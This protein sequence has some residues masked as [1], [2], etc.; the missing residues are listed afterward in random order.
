MFWRVLTRHSDALP[1]GGGY[2]DEDY[3]DIGR[4]RRYDEDYGRRRDDG[5]DRINDQEDDYYRDHRPSAP[6][7]TVSPPSSPASPPAPSSPS[8]PPSARTA[9]LG[10]PSVGVGCI[11]AKAL[12]AFGYPQTALDTRRIPNPGVRHEKTGGGGLDRWKSSIHNNANKTEERIGR[13]EQLLGSA[14]ASATGTVLER[15][16]KAESI[17]RMVNTQDLDSLAGRAKLIR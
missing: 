5:Y 9:S 14:S 2:P 7:K 13:L 8:S 15:L 10:R 1:R 3:D 6:S 17:V 11:P 4:D 12:D 16:E